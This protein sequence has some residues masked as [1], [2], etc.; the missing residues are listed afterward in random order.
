MKDQFQSPKAKPH[1]FKFLDAAIILLVVI[2][3][4]ACGTS[5]YGAIRNVANRQGRTTI[6][7]AAVRLGDH[8]SLQNMDFSKHPLNLVL[9][10]S[11]DCK[12]CARS[13]SFHSLLIKHALRNGIG[14][15]LLLAPAD[16]DSAYVKDLTNG[17]PIP[18]LV[19]DPARLRIPGTPT[20]I[21]VNSQG[22]ITDVWTGL[23]TASE[24][25]GILNRM[26]A[27]SSTS[28]FVSGTLSD[29]QFRSLANSNKVVLLDIRERQPFDQDHLAMAMNIPAD[30]LQIRARHELDQSK[31]IVINCTNLPRI[32]CSSSEEALRERGFSKILF[33]TNN[34]YGG[35]SCLSDLPPEPGAS[36]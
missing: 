3:A 19:D 21:G 5:I 32:A 31:T 4:V 22:T 20:I 15:A 28:D 24:E 29:D 8:L 26:V 7:H 16:R 10:V 25:R 14:V 1:T 12:Y 34:P 18:T 2:C 6:Q 36:Q 33:L 11:K 30:E 9:V 13:K 27:K 35:L 23:A 17:S